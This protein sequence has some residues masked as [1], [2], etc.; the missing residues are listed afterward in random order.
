M[1]YR[2]RKISLSILTAIF[3]SADPGHISLLA[4]FIAW[5][6][7]FQL[8]LTRYQASLFKHLRTE[9]WRLDEDEYNES[10]RRSD[11]KKGGLKPI[12]DLGYSGSVRTL[13]QPQH[14]AKPLNISLP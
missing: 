8:V 11:G 4:R 10:F 14:L 3:P 12:G 1:G 6:S 9:V 13:F 7:L 5:F 2:D